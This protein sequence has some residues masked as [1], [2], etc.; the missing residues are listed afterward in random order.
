[1]V[2][3]LESSVGLSYLPDLV[4]FVVMLDEKACRG[5]VSQI[6]EMG[7]KEVVCAMVR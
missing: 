6:L 3:V 5:A 4:V 2:A 7:E 1:M